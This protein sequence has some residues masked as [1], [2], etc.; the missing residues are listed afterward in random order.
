MN[1][2]LD[3]GTVHVGDSEVRQYAIR[4][5]GCE[6]LSGSITACPPEFS[7]W[8]D[9]YSLEADGWEFI[10][11]TF[12]PLQAGAR[13]CTIDN[14]PGC[15]LVICTGAGENGNGNGGG[16]CPFLFAWN[17]AEFEEDNT[18]LAACEIN[19]EVTVTDYYMLSRTLVPTNKEY[20]LQIREFETR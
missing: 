2:S 15:S 10:T 13:S 17:G 20:R 14:G 4:N 9:S 19:P 1:E 12:R 7:V 3:F 6:T 11:V 18:I 8:P 5:T 16:G